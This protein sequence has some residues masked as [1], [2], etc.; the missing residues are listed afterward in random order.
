VNPNYLK[1]I[2]RYSRLRLMETSYL[3]EIQRRGRDANPF[4]QLLEIE[5][6]D[7]G[8]GEAELFMRVMPCMH[9]CVGWLQGGLF[10]ALCDEAMALALYTVLEEEAGIATISESTSFLQGVRSGKVRAVGNVVK[11]GRRVAFTGGRV[12]SED[13]TTLSETR[14]SF[15]I[16]P[17][18]ENR[19]KDQQMTATARPA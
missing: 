14:A 10:T 9:N 11:K 3:E 6:G 7:Y 5:I 1:S 13:G 15:V 2:P 16:M 18:S 12:E 19:T 4:F 17:K 8:R